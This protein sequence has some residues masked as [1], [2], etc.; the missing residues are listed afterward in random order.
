M[1]EERYAYPLA[2]PGGDRQG[3]VGPV[4]GGWVRGRVVEGG[5]AVGRLDT[6][7]RLLDFSRPDPEPAMRSGDIVSLRGRELAGVLVVDAAQVLAPALRSTWQSKV[8]GC[9][10][11]SRWQAAVAA[12]REFFAARGFVE[13]DT[14]ALVRAPG[15]EPYLDP[16]VTQLHTPGGA[17]GPR[18]LITSPE[19]HL[20]QLLGRGCERIFQV[21]HCF[22]DGE[23]SRHHR[24]EFTMVEWYRAW[25][26]YREVADD[27]AALTAHVSQRLK[28]ETHVTWRGGKLELAP[29]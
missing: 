17:A 15:Q 13:V 6:G 21:C 23:A 5:S 4:G 22:R 19:H 3:A 27:V 28:G 25:A 16:F 1:S 11:S 20:K 26:T 7:G 29:P 12:V 8:Q 10:A 2:A 9:Q 18:Y 24:P 14:P